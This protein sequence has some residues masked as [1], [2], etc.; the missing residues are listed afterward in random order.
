M[1]GINVVERID[2]ALLCHALGHRCMILND[3]M[4]GIIACHDIFGQL[5]CHLRCRGRFIAGIIHHDI[6]GFF[7]KAVTAE[8][9]IVDD[10]TG[11]RIRIVMQNVV[12]Q[13]V[14]IVGCL[15]FECGAVIIDRCQLARIQ[16]LGCLRLRLCDFLGLCVGFRTGSRCFF[17]TRCK[18]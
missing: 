18:C 11:L 17:R 2:R 13:A 10:L 3:Q 8:Q 1:N 15:N 7:H 5:C 16:K 9:R 4:I 6:E 12:I 14:D